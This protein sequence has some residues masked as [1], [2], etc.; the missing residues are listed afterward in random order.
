MKTLSG[1]LGVIEFVD[2][3]HYTCIVRT[4]YGL[5]QN[6]PITPVLLSPS[7]QG[8]WFLPEV[9]TRVMVGTIGKGTGNEYTFMIGAAYAVDQDP[10]DDDADAVKDEGTEETATTPDF[11]NNRPVLQ[12]G[13]IVL[14]SSDRNFVIMR[15]GGIIEVG[16]TQMAK[17]FYIPLQNVIRDLSQIYEMQNSAGLFQ[18]TRKESDLTWGKT[19]LEIPAIAT[20]GTATTETKEVDK[21]PTEL[22]LRVRE[23]ESDDAP[24]VSIDL[25]AVTRTTISEEGLSDDMSGSMTHGAYSEINENNNL[26][27]L[28][29]RININNNVKVFI[30]KNGNYTSAVMGAE[31]HTHCGP[32]Y[33]EVYQGR[34]IADFQSFYRASYESVEEEIDKVKVTTAG[35]SVSTIVGTADD[36]QTSWTVSGD[37][38]DLTSK[39]E[40]NISGSKATIKSDG[41]LEIKSGGDVAISCDNFVIS[42]MGTIEHV[43]SGSIS[44]SVLNSDLSNVAYQI[45]NESSGEIQIHNSLGAI[46]LSSLGRPSS[47]GQGGIG[48]SGAGVISEIVIKPN[49]TIRMEHLAGGVVTSS[50]EINT[51]GC[52]MTTM[53]GELSID[54]AGQVNIGG[55]STGAGNGRVVTTL[56]HPVCFVTGAPIGGSTSVGASSVGLLYGPMTPTTFTTDPT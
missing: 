3:T 36:P 53:G 51:T 37:G 44:Q 52:S 24:S 22:N 4:E 20:D 8:I 17:R 29:A 45:V 49:G 14:S 10:F 19:T 56:T 46:R 26:A 7:G 31:I 2:T 50:V 38:A 9:G 23:F 43:Y 41:L 1:D 55:G 16:A 48:T 12:T 39:G 32:R 13:D 6:V 54:Q 35:E 28:L 30:D 15:K 42:T 33:E 21:V 40:V 11:R 34:Y 25:G 5:H 47:G 27:H 18:M